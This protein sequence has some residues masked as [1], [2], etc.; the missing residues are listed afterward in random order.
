MDAALE[1]ILIVR[2]PIS[3]ADV[4]DLAQKWYG[5]MIKG[6]AD[7]DKGI[8]ALGG[9]WHIDA[10]TI[11][12]ADGSQQHNLWG[13]NIY[14][15]ERDDAALEYQSLINIRPAQGNRDMELQDVALR[16]KIRSIV[17]TLVRELF[18]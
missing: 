16:Q 10:N 4:Q 8:V 1:D 9:D 13:F 18:V 3:L 17:A 5:D 14:V 12:I 2:E 15:Q 6:V 7:V 11:L